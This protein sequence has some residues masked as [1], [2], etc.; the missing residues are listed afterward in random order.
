MVTIEDEK[1]LRIFTDKRLSEEVPGDTLGD[2]FKGYVFRISGGFDKQ[3]FAMV[4]GVATNGRV[5]L[6]LDGSTS[7]YSPKRPG[8]RKRKSIRGCIVGPDLSCLNLVIVKKGPQD[9]PGLTD[10]D[11]NKPSMR[12]PKRA[13]RIR[14]LWGLTKDDDVRLF[15]PKRKIVKEGKK[16]QVKSPKIQRLVT[17]V[18][19]RR[20][21]RRLALKKQRYAHNQEQKAKYEQILAQVRKEKRAALLSKK[22]EADS[23]RKSVK[24]GSTATKDKPAA[25]AKA[26]AA[27]PAKDAPAAAAKAPAAV[28]AKDAPA[29]AA[30]APAATPAKAAT[31]GQ[32]KAAA[33]AKAGVKDTP[34]PAAG[35][36]TDTKAPAGA[37]KTDKPATATKAPAAAPAKADT[38][39]QAPKT[40]TKPQ[41]AKDAP[42]PA[43]P[44]A[45][46]PA[47]TPAASTPAASTPAATTPAASTPAATTAAPPKADAKPDTKAPA[48]TD[49]KPQPPKGGQG[50]GPKKQ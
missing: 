38:K 48:K 26:P 49:A 2:D 9:L 25:A 44:T 21:R 27:V 4:Q 11:S 3:G 20:K 36:K 16:D 7:M 33:P 40:D 46:P 41:P 39:T 6:M 13:S 1:K 28:P 50:K 35:A 42:K 15:V 37:A 17:P 5:R 12:G 31:K 24:P 10:P 29:A 22:R 45:A 32:P 47:T 14:K 30:K 23:E 8:C 34:K 43:T 19:L 18:T